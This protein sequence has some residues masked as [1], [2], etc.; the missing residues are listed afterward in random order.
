MS[1]LF[2]GCCKIE[3]VIVISGHLLLSK[4]KSCRECR[5][6]SHRIVGVRAV[7]V[8]AE[9]WHVSCTPS[10]NLLSSSSTQNPGLC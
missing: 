3:F 10:L 5:K 8:S 1:F 7:V 4:V 6:P 2:Y 9:R